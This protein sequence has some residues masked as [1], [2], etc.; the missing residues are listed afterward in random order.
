MTGHLVLSTLHTN[1][2]ITSAM[3]LIDVGIPGYLAAA[4]LR[5]VVA[6]RLVRRI[7]DGC[8]A[9]YEPDAYEHSW[10]NYMLNENEAAKLVFHKGTGC[11]YCNNTG[12]RGR[13]GVFEFLEMNE[14][15]MAALRNNDSQGFAESAQKQQ[16]FRSLMFC[17]LD[18]ASQ[19]ITTLEEVFRVAEQLE[20]PESQEM[21]LKRDMGEEW[22]NLR[23]S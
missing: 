7:C 14:A 9:P 1:D 23:I 6:Q 2:A 19:G 12:Y 8:K 17:T 11:T 15:M 20:D 16:Y 5:G 3:R 13:I 21:V 18:Y 22:L 4:A 10:L